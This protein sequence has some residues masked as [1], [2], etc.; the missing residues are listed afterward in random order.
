M[1]ITSR[2]CRCL[3]FIEQCG[4]APFFLSRFWRIEDRFI[5]TLS[6]QVLRCWRS[7]QEL[8]S[9]IQWHLTKCWRAWFFNGSQDTEIWRCNEIYGFVINWVIVCE[10]ERET[11]EVSMEIPKMIFSRRQLWFIKGGAHLAVKR[12]GLHTKRYLS[13]GRLPSSWWVLPLDPWLMVKRW[14]WIAA[15]CGIVVD[16]IWLDESFSQKEHCAG[17]LSQ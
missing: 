16:W 11:Y 10:R 3:F 2:W 6:N 4:L 8:L 7:R 14:T 9:Q 1:Q 5:F 17:R 13:N 12:D 15:V